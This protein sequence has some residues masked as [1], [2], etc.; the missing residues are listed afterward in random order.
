MIRVIHYLPSINCTSGIAN[1]IMNYYRIIDKKNFQFHF[2]YFSRKT[3]NNFEEEIK[4]LGGTV[5]YILPPTKLTKFRKD[6]KHYIDNLKKIYPHDDFIFQNHQI[7]FTLFMYKIIKKCGI[8]HIIVHN[9]MTKFSDTKLK[10]IRNMILFV[11]SRRNDIKYFS[12]SDSANKLIMKYANKNECDIF[13]MNN[14]IDFSKF[15]HSLSDRDKI[16]SE[17]KIGNS[18][19]V[20]HIGHFEPVK[21]HNFIMDIFEKLYNVNHEYKLL[22]IG[23]GSQKE[24]FLKIIDEKNFKNNVNVLSERNDIPALLSAMDCFIF[25]SKFEGL[26]IAAVEAQ[27]NGLIT[28]ISDKVPSEVILI[29]CQQLS[30]HSSDKWVDYIRNIEKKDRV[31]ANKIVEQSKFNIYKNIE[32]LEKEYYKI[33]EV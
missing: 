12:C 28:L 5:D 19:L 1:L 22:L 32:N 31:Y 10:A 2:I 30:L 17:L 3:E 15:K 4:S 29:N 16:R 20:G 21:N 6:L 23:N 25:P 33:L 14:G 9:H 7:A 11:L 18:F 26:G 13:V 24:K 8:N 27:A